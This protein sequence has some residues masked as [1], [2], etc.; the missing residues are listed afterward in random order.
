MFSEIFV[1]V[2]NARI[3]RQLAFSLTAA[4]AFSLI[5]AERCNKMPLLMS[6][7]CDWQVSS[8]TLSTAHPQIRATPQTRA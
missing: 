6:I 2:W 7:E 3:F 5:G 1:P 8:Q 4:V